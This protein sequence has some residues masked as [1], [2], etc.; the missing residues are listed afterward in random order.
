MRYNR[1][2][3]YA[4]AITRRFAKEQMSITERL[5]RIVNFGRYSIHGDIPVIQALR[6]WRNNAGAVSAVIAMLPC[7][8]LLCVKDRFQKKVEKTHMEYEK[9][10]NVVEI[11]FEVLN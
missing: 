4:L 8:L 7:S 9:A 5:V 10:L 6:L 1:G 3:A 2:H 11:D